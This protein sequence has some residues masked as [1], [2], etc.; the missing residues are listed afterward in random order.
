MKTLERLILKYTISAIYK[1]SLLMPIRKRVVF[2]TN[3]TTELTDNFKYIYEEMQRQQLD[4]EYK[5]LLKKMEST[6]I[7]RL[8]YF[9]HLLK[10]TYYLATSAHF[11]VDDYYFPVYVIKPRKGTEISQVWHACGAF[12]KFGYS[13]LDKEYGA[14]NSY[15]KLIPIH[16][17]YSHVLVS[18]PEVAKYYAEA[19]NMGEERIRSIG[20]PRTDIFFNEKMKEEA[21]HKVYEKY[22]VLKGKKLILYAPT[23]RGATQSTINTSIPFDIEQVTGVLD[24][25]TY[26][27]FKMHPLVK[28]G[29]DLKGY[30]N[31]IDLSDYPEINELLLISDCL[32]TDYSSTV[33]E[34]A[35]LERPMIFYAHDREAYLKERDFY[36]DYETFVPGPIVET[37]EGLIEVLQ[38][39]NFDMQKVSEFKQKFFNVADGQSSK[40]FVEEIILGKRKND[41]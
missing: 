30:H 8:M 20:I 24:D 19:F 10:A 3:R 16:K 23:F 26:L 13:I 28:K 38:A 14:D 9:L 17:N 33:F 37:T 34:Y 5:F 15:V 12:K 18:S 36:Y 29:L 39:N 1:I 32:I 4:F 6:L 2:A 21:I 25:N 27:G 11:I 40:R 35:L 31:M 41:L 7:G 22:P